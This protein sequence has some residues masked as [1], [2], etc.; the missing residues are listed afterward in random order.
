MSGRCLGRELRLPA[1]RDCLACH[2]RFVVAEARTL[3]SMKHTD[4]PL[5]PHLVDLPRDERGYVVP[6]EVHWSAPDQPILKMNE[7][8]TKFL[9]TG[10]RA[11][12]ICGLEIGYDE[13][14]WRMFNEREGQRIRRIMSAQGNY[15][16]ATEVPGHLVCMLY[17]AI[18]CPAWR[19]PTDFR[20]K[21]PLLLGFADY[22]YIRSELD[23]EFT[24]GHA[25]PRWVYRP[26]P[27]GVHGGEFENPQIDLFARYEAESASANDSYLARGERRHYGPWATADQH[28]WRTDFE[29]AMAARDTDPESF[30]STT[31]LDDGREI[32]LFTYY[33]AGWMGPLQRYRAPVTTPVDRAT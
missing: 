4:V 14:C 11:C 27:A 30:T 21:R 9:L 12:A 23:T 29:A 8:R 7:P 31:T 10:Y 13:G 22:G 33:P 19:A 17:A 26:P 1:S 32:P 25:E 28:R 15:E 24:R 5:A 6:A 2:H 20:G 18:V 16:E 3:A